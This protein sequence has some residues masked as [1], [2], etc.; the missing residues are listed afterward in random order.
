MA[1][2]KLILLR[3]QFN[4]CCFHALSNF[5]GYRC[6]APH[7][8]PLSLSLLVYNELPSLARKLLPC[9]QRRR[10]RRLLHAFLHFVGRQSVWIIKY[11]HSHTLTD[12]AKQRRFT[13]GARGWGEERR[14]AL[15]GRASHTWGCTLFL[16]STTFGFN[17]FAACRLCLVFGEG[18]FIISSFAFLICRLPYPHRPTPPAERRNHYG[19]ISVASLALPPYLMNLCLCSRAPSWLSAKSA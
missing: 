16:C 8:P 17:A 1:K 19:C 5:P 14:S 15:W 18:F 7:C 11:A 10:R 9:L 12:S 3:L 13:A 2:Q 6:T 4:I